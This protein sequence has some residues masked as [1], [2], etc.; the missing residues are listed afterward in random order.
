MLPARSTTLLL[1]LDAFNT[2]FRPRLPVATQYAQTARSLGFLPE[3]VT[4]DTVQAAFR[5]AFKKESA[6][7]P[8]YGRHTPG[9]GGPREWWGNVIRGCFASLGGSGPAGRSVGDVEV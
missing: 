6:E 1:T 7:R 9:F 2:I 8:N 4:P 3:T 5:V